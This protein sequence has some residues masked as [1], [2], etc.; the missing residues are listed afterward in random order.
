MKI[1]LAGFKSLAGKITNEAHNDVH[2]LS[3]FFEH[4]N[5]KYG[6]YVEF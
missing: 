3:S 6:D 2:L 5:G 4:K 1:Y